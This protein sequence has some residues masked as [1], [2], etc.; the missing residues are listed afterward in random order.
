MPPFNRRRLLARA[1]ALGSA[2][3]LGA[4]LIARASASCVQ[5]ESEGLRQSLNYTEVAAD[6]AQSCAH[7][8]FFTPDAAAA[9]CGACAIL[10]GPADASG[11][12]DSWSPPS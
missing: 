7:C 12:C 8:A 3:G 4:G 6:A 10:S 5:P 9:G 2:A 1:L 11:H